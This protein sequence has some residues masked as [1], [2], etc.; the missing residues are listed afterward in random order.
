MTSFDIQVN[1]FIL[2]HIRRTDALK[3]CS[4]SSP[5]D[6]D[7]LFKKSFEDCPSKKMKVLFI[8]DDPN[9]QYKLDI[10]NV[11]SKNGFAPIQGD[12]ALSQFMTEYEGELK[13]EL[14]QDNYFLFMTL[15]NLGSK[16]NKHMGKR[17]HYDCDIEKASGMCS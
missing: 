7:N 16:T 11:I 6:I 17:R 8:T 9:S 1:E 15:R 3:E 13:P 10:M 14:K 12:V 2:L 5:A 4:S